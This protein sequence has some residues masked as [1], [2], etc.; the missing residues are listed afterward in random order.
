MSSLLIAVDVG[1]GSARA[2]VFDATGQRLGHG[3]AEIELWRFPGERVEQSSANIWQAVVDAV[4]RSLETAN[5][6]PNDVGGLGFDATCSLVLSDR[7]GEPLALGDGL[8]ARDVIVWMDHRAVGEA[9]EFTATGDAALEQVGGVMS[10]EMQLPKLL[11][12][13]RNTPEV[14]RRLGAA[15]DLS[16]WLTWRATGDDVRSSCTT[17]CKWCL[18]YRARIDG[19]S[20]GWPQRL[21]DRIEM[22]DLLD[23]D[24]TKV[25][26]KIDVPGSP[27]G[28]GLSSVAASELGLR[29]GTPVAVSAIDA[30]AGAIGVL[31]SGAAGKPTFGRL[32]MITGTSNCHLVQSPDRLPVPG[33]WG[34]YF[35][36]LTGAAW[37]AEAG[38]SAAG[39]FLDRL[40]EGHPAREAS[41]AKEYVRLDDA[42]A[43][44]LADQDADRF[45]G[46]RLVLPDFLGNRSPIADPTMAGAITGLTLDA[47]RRDL[48]RTY[49][50]GLF[51]L[52]YGT[53]HIVEA[54]EAGGHAI[55]AIVATG[56]GSKNR[57]LMQAHADATGLPVY[58][59]SES[60]GVLL[61]SAMLAA[62]A[63]GF[64][65]SLEDAMAGMCTEADRID[66][67]VGGRPMHDRR[68]HKT[69]TLQDFLR[70]KGR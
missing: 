70:G 65:P 47:D 17:V 55:N 46:D 36:A 50:A 63:A 12:L 67:D 9:E 49:L 58:L 27:I 56:S 22:T 54:L 11:W 3:A 42:L 25:G 31:A 5:A 52:A 40:I 69:R 10:P 8:L 1:T 32:A 29:P 59:P 13:K 16:D 15:H 39:A 51:A 45:L 33:V 6:G 44:L 4:K 24:C 18:D 62:R 26:R 48:A 14:W 20:D 66:P 38:Q 57:R 60:E 30:H 43:D 61:G 34:P 19:N 53:R 37:L 7:N 41:A 28:R 68:Y 35:G 64:Y 21:L 2:G 23:G